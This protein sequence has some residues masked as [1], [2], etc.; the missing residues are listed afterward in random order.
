MKDFQKRANG[1]N[2]QRDVLQ[3]RGSLLETNVELTVSSVG[4]SFTSE[5]IE[6]FVMKNLLERNRIDDAILVKVFVDESRPKHQKQ[7][8]VFL[9]ME[10]NSRHVNARGNNHFDSRM[11]GKLNKSNS[12]KV[13]LSEELISVIG[14]ILSDRASAAFGNAQERDKRV[15]VIPLDIFAILMIMMKADARSSY[16]K[17]GDVKNIRKGK[18]EENMV[19][20]TGIKVMNT[21][22]KKK[23]KRIPNDDSINAQLM[24]YI[25]NRRRFE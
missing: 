2:G 7:I 13:K 19:T 10:G 15:C 20:F 25:E 21:G 4:V 9:I 12:S 8:Q 14:P 17:I 18:G 24:G 3:F 6:N 5:M 1:Q 16:I 11:I 22:G 23:N